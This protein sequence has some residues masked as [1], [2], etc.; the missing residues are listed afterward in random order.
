MNNSDRPLSPEA[1]ALL[2]EM[3]CQGRIDEGAWDY[4]RNAASGAFGGA[5]KGAGVGGLGGAIAGPAGMAGGAL[6]GAVGGAVIGGVRGLAGQGFG[7]AFGWR[8]A[9][10][11]K[12]AVEEYKKKV[13]SHSSPEMHKSVNRAFAH[14]EKAVDEALAYLK[15]KYQDAQQQAKQRQARRPDRQSPAVRHGA[16]P[17]PIIGRNTSADDYFDNLS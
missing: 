7:D 15:D 5:V 6:A 9:V 8:L 11:V 14:I 17:G 3:Y 4:I 13:L 16:K 1:Y 10:G 2:T 12:P